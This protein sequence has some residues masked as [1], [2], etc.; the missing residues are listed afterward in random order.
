MKRIQVHCAV[1]F[2]LS[3]AAIAQR[4]PT[5]TG[6]SH[7]TLYADDLGKSRGFYG[8]LLGWE[9]IPETASEAGVRFYANHAQY[10]ELLPPPRAGDDHRYNLIAFS[11]DDADGLRKLLGSK[12]VTVPAIVTVEED[13][14]S[15][16]IVH[17]PEGN[18]V[19][20]TQQ[21]RK[22]P[23]P[24]KAALARRLSTHIMHS[25]YNVRDRVAMDRF[26]RDA[27]GF[28]LYWQGGA[29]PAEV[30]WVMM[31]VPDGTDWV[32]YMLNLP[33]RPSRAQLGSADH[34][35]PG[36][37]SVAELQRILEQRGWKA[38]VGKNPQVLG[39]DGKMQLDLNDPDGTRVEFM[40]FAPVKT[41]CCSAYT[42]TQPSAS[43]AW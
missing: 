39:V 29:K 30:D 15:S 7:V 42:G 41:P 10:V 16:F 1:I 20:F 11:T 13:G 22:V 24:Q 34:I 9:A 43:D 3:G 23:S 5:I 12:G 31:Q 6:I 27:L 18:A 14:S 4:S 40:E 37:A 2:L 19:A 32:E 38:P 25:G 17:D 35:A 28:H 26:Y 21:G 33:A 8:G 36:V